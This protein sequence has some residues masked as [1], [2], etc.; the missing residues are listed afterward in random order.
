MH[1][2]II[3][4]LG[5]GDAGKGA[6]VDSLATDQS[7]VVRFNG[8]PQ[9]AH[10][11]VRNRWHHTFAQFGSG[12]MVGARTHLSRFML[13]NP[14]N[15]LTEERHL[16]YLGFINSFGLTT[17]DARA[18][19]ITPFHVAANR[20]REIARADGRHGSCGQGVGEARRLELQG[21]YLC[22]DDIGTVRCDDVLEAIRLRLLGEIGEIFEGAVVHNATAQAEWQIL[23]QTDL[24]PITKIY[25]KWARLVT[26][27]DD[28]WIGEYDGRLIF[29]GAQGVLL[30]ETHGFGPH[31]TW[32]DC[33]P[34]NA[35]TL[36]S[37]AGVVGT[38]IGVVRSYMTRHGAGPFPTEW[39]V[40]VDFVATSRLPEA[41]AEEHNG[42][43]EFQGAWRVGRLDLPLLR[44]AIDAC[45]GDLGGLVITHLDKV[46]DDGWFV[47][48]GYRLDGHHCNEVEPFRI[49]DV[50]PVYNWWEEEGWA[51]ASHVAEELGTPIAM[52]AFGPTAKDR[53]IYAQV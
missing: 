45:G 30:D 29:E 8:G 4:D 40:E 50:T 34:N 41:L 12:T 42:T 36:C 43:G 28:D 9:A 15:M 33:T 53:H 48:E 13:I 27:R 35:L 25:E 47:C 44:Y 39:D 38:P 3:V 6:T 20:I 11:V 2:P 32:T 10:N 16:D 31:N 1:N 5:F 52:T 49:D 21:L 46:P 26:F 17:V 7:L 24:R 14:P 51:Y 23:C 18:V 19:I 37:E 22:P